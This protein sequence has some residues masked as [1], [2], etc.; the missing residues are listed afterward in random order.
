MR[1]RPQPGAAALQGLGRLPAFTTQEV[2]SS[3]AEVCAAVGVDVEG[4]KH[5][6]G[7][8]LNDLST[9]AESAQQPFILQHPPT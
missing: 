7:S 9:G 6:V 8:A 5:L 4:W 3:F 2:E 1:L